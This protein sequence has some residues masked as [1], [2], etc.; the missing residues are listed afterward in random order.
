MKSGEGPKMYDGYAEY[1][2]FRTAEGCTDAPRVLVM[3]CRNEEEEEEG[4]GECDPDL[5]Y[6]DK[7]H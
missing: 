5:P 4:E 2:G 3:H 6:R 7:C 1:L